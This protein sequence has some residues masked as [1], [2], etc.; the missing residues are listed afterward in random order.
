MVKVE[1]GT[2][3]MGATKEQGSNV[4]DREKPAH[5][6][7]LSDY[8]IGE[9]VVKQELWKAVMGNNP[10][11]WEGDNLPVEGVSWNDAQEFI[12][13][14]NKE[15]GREFRLPTEAEWEY[16]ARGGKKSKRFRY[17]G[18][19][20]I[21]EV[22]W[23][24]G[25]SGVKTHPVKEKKAN[26]LGLYDMSG[27]V[28]EWCN[29]WFGGYSSDAQTNPQG[30]KKGSFRVLCGGSW[31]DYAGYCRVSYRNYSTPMSHDINVGFRL[32]MCP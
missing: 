12:A 3:A 19:N 26:K 14:L 8:Y 9:T 1:G 17:S 30:P 27:N 31:Y 32:V 28:W 24:A 21:D 16:A 15:T 11:N 25:N 7:A 20:S 18:S 6:V 13:K 2:F 29:D 4:F 22:A 5:E 10:S 23:Y